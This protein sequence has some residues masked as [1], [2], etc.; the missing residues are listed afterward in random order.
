MELPLVSVIC[1]CY[2]HERFVKEAIRSVIGQT[3]ASLEIIVVDDASLDNSR[4]EI[5]NIIAINPQIRFIRLTKNI[6]NCAAFNV[7][8]SHA[9]GHYVVD[10]A[11]DD[12][13]NPRRIEKQVSFFESLDNSYGVVFSDVRYID[14]N[15]KPLYQHYE[16]LLKRKLIQFIPTGDVYKDLLQ[17]YFISAP[18]MLVRKVVF[19]ELKGYD[20]TLAYEDFDF[21][22]RSSRKFKYGFL[23]EVLTDVR[24]TKGSLGTRAYMPGDRQLYSTYLVCR[25][26]HQLNQSR[27]EHD[28]LVSRIR[29]ELRH[30]ALSGNHKE[31]MLFFFFLKEISPLALPDYMFSWIARLRVPLMGLR[32][33]YHTLRYE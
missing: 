27:S 9:R 18:S 22:I 4:T 33:L 30:A 17:M 6:G 25:K 11:T 14:E 5:E 32:R 24:K 13:M 1:L 12:V 19:D 7:G 21:W 26:A 10:F 2:N 20:E 8:L 15:G 28:A 16:N 31:A 23:N 3:Y 29:Y